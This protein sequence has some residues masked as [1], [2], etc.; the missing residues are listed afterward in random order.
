MKK[1]ALILAIAASA[2]LAPACKDK[3]EDRADTKKVISAGDV[4][5]TVNSAF[6]AKYPGASDVIWEDA[7]EGTEKSYKVKFKK[8][9]T[10][11]KA[12]FNADGTLIKEK[13]DD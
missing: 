9:D 10:Y 6:A 2:L 7:H 8:G 1:T 4:P 3:K 11:W 13:A 12:E 5:G